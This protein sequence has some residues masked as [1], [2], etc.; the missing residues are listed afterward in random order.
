MTQ[1]F[2]SVHDQD[3]IL[4]LEKNR[5]FRNIKKYKYIFLGKRPIDKL[6]K[7]KNKVIIA[8]DLKNNIE[9]QKCMFDYTGWYALVKNNLIKE[10]YVTIVHYDCLLKEGFDET[11]NKTFK[12]H[13]DCVISF[14]PHLLTCDYFISEEF[15]SVIIPACKEVY[16]IDIRKIV[17]EAIQRGDKYWP[18]GGSFAC[19]KEWLEKY[20]DWV[21]P[22]KPLLMQD[23]MCS[24]NVERAMKFFDLVHNIQEEYLPDIMEHI[25]NAAHDQAYQPEEIK[26]AQRKR[27]DDFINGRLFS[28]DEIQKLSFAEKIFSVKNMGVH[29]C[30]TLFGLK[31]KIK[32][33]KLLIRELI[34]ERNLLAQ[35]RDSLVEE[36]NKL[37]AERNSYI[38]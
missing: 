23:K 19:S 37:L 7:L 26:I 28:Q 20:V 8:R 16:N 13:P 32:S 36:R 5:C 18:G 14:Q 6:K 33:Q 11:I 17:D 15:A 3:L 2:I 22:M 1:I 12:E 30:L 27:F 34:N 21:E 9:E 29:K 31:L 25:F 4:Q 10:K 38:K 35:E 24:H